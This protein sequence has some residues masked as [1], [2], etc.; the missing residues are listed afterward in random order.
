[1]RSRNL[2]G[3]DT[4]ETDP[5]VPHRETTTM[6]CVSLHR[7]TT[8]T[9]ARPANYTI[10]DSQWSTPWLSLSPG[11]NM[12][13]KGGSNE[14][15][16]PAQVDVMRPLLDEFWNSSVS[17]TTGRGASTTLSFVGG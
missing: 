14:Y 3:W 12:L 13:R 15:I 4:T 7:S 17:W 10:D 16:S 5:V 8:V 1:M 11:W 6:P 9:H 2:D